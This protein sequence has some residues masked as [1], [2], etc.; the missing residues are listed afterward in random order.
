VERKEVRRQ[1]VVDSGGC[2]FESGA[3]CQAVWTRFSYEPIRVINI[4]YL[5]SELPL[6]L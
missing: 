1:E 4:V 3:S 6:V 2:H 5:R